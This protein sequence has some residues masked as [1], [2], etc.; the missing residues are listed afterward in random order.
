MAVAPAAVRN[1]WLKGTPAT[2]TTTPN[3]SQT[4]LKR[5]SFSHLGQLLLRERNRIRGGR[6]VQNCCRGFAV[7]LLGSVLVAQLFVRFAKQ[8]LNK[9]IVLVGFVQFLNRS[10]VVARIKCDV[11]FQI[12][13]VKCLLRDCAFV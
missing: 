3:S 11:A 8:T 7:I 13:E 1:R 6:I 9:R 5:V 10:L 12:R 2:T 4:F